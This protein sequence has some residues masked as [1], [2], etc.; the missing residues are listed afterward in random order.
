MARV[1]P[2]RTPHFLD[3][4]AERAVRARLAGIRHGRITLLDNETRQEYGARSARCPLEVTVQVHDER[5]WSELAFGGSIGAG[6]A[7][8]EGYWSTDDLTALVR[9][10]LQNREVLDGLETS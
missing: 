1:A 3:S 2:R 4:F 6:E 5:F 10:L 9:I 8:M 7:Y